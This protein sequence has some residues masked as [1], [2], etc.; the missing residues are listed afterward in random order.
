MN[1]SLQTATLFVLLFAFSFLSFNAI[2]AFL[3][4]KADLKNEQSVS[5]QGSAMTMN[6]IMI[7]KQSKQLLELSETAKELSKPLSFVVWPHEKKILNQNLSLLLQKQININPFDSTLWSQLSMAQLE[8]S[9]SYN[10]RAW[11]LLTNTS[12]NSWKTSERLLI[13]RHCIVAREAFLSLVPST[14]SKLINSLPKSYS[15]NALAVGMGLNQQFLKWFLL[16]NK[17]SHPSLITR[18]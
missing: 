12:F 18:K 14:C 5:G 17:I 7:S 3:I 10:E 11:T 16:N 4:K 13:T 8:A 6:S 9:T 2:K 15:L 1:K